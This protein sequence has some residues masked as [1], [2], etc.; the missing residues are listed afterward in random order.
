MTELNV[1]MISTLRE[2]F[3]FFLQET[4]FY[5]PEYRTRRLR[6]KLL[7]HYGER[8]AL[9][10]K[11]QA[12]DEIVYSYSLTSKEAIAKFHNSSS[13]EKVKVEQT[14]MIL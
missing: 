3:L 6:E 14:A 12:K 5:N 13:S 9:H 8:L 10:F 7:R 2:R 4:D 1:E 11:Q